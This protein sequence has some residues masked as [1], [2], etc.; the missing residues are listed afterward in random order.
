M[1]LIEAIL[2]AQHHTLSIIGM[3][4]NAGKTVTLNHLIDDAYERGISLGMTSIGRDG[5]ALDLVTQTDKPMIYVYEGTLIATASTLFEHA[6]A[7]L[8]ILKMTNETTAMGKI[9]IAKV[10]HEGY[11]QIAGPATTQGIKRISHDMRLLGAEL[12]LIDG[13]LDRKS[14]ASP[15]I[16]DA[17]ILATGAVLNRDLDQVIVKTHHR[18]KLFGLPCVSHLIKAPMHHAI[19]TRGVGL[20]AGHGSD[21]VTWLALKTALGA[22]ATIAAHMTDDT[23]HILLPGSLVDTVVKDIL[24][25]R[26]HLRGVKVVVQDATKVFIDEKMYPYFEKRGLQIEVLFPINLIGVTLNPTSPV[27][28]T[29][30]SDLFLEKMVQALAPI[31]VYDVQTEDKAWS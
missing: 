2:N 31:A 30:E 11:V 24:S 17:T 1:K 7:G 9:I 3:A 28:Y 8:E 25:V 4:K 13:A 5:E 23:T 18:V 19:E 12:V 20:M 21:Q 22:G 10:R 16:T 27:G 15:S 14:L 6:E 29:F 26:G